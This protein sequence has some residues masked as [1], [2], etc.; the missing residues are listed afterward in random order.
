MLYNIII[1][2]TILF[3]SVSGIAELIF[4]SQLLSFVGI[5]NNAQT[6]FL[7]RT[8]AV[9]LL[10]LLPSLWTAF[11]DPNSPSAKSALLGTAAYMFLGSA[12][13]FHAYTQR[14]VN[15]MSVPSVIFRVLLG[16]TI[17]WLALRK[18]RV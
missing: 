14:I 12:V 16:V 2:F 15:S 18:L 11:R 17:V 4:P 13:D 9:A 8:T 5:P 7:L 6:D 1:P 3:I 10:A